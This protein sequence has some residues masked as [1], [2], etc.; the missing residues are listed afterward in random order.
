MVVEKEK[1][2]INMRYTGC[3]KRSLNFMFN[4]VVD[5]ELNFT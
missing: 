4:N 2:K 1:G 5:T 3:E